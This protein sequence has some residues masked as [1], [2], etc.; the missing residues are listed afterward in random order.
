MRTWLLTSVLL[1]S[2]LARG[3]VPP[4]WRLGG[5]EAERYRAEVDRTV[6]HAGKASVRLFSVE[7]S[8]DGAARLGQRLDAGDFAGARIRLAGWVRTKGVSGRSALWLRVS[9]QH[10]VLAFDNMQQR[11]LRGDSEWTRLEIVLDAPKESVRLSYG[12]SLQGPGSAW[13]DDV[14]L[15]RVDASVPLSPNLLEGPAAPENLDLEQAGVEPWFLSGGARAEYSL[16]QVASPVHGGAKALALKPTASSPHGY[17]VAMQAFDAKPW[18][19]KR[20][21]VAAFIKTSQVTARGDFWARAQGNDSPDDGPGLSSASVALPPTADWVRFELVFE[22]PEDALDVQLGAGIQGPG[23]LWIDDVK[24][25]AVSRS[26]PLAPALPK[27]PVNP[28]FEER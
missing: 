8:A 19:G 2:S 10:R 11:G 25:E 17:G 15:E 26:V 4:G 1:L 22:V 20:V 14:S 13:L 16:E 3:A 6:S 23:Q 27:V 28:S 21:R 7:T 24:V 18:R 9:G 5:D 12:L